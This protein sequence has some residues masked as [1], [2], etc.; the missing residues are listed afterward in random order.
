M[1]R[2]SPLSLLLLWLLLI[3]P[4]LRAESPASAPANDVM[5]AIRGDDW[6]RA[7]ALAGQI[8][9]PIAGKLV[10][11]YRLLAPGAPGAASAAS[12]DEIADFIAV[13]PDWPQ[14]DL[15]ARRRDEALVALADDRAA[16]AFCV[17]APPV[18]PMAWFRCAIAA[19]ASGDEAAALRAATLAWSAGI[20][21][22]VAT[23]TLLRR[24][25]LALTPAATWQRFTR[26]L[27]HSA[28]AAGGTFPELTPAQQAA[29]RAVLALRADQPDAADRLAALPEAT[30]AWPLVFLETAR[31]LRRAGRNT[32]ALALWQRS[33]VAAAGA[34]GDLG[35]AFWGERDKLARQALASGD[36]NTAYAVVDGVF[37]DDTAGAAL[38]SPAARADAIFLAGF[39]AL[40]SLHQPARAE[41]HFR[42][43]AALSPAVITQARAHY[44]LA[45][46]AAARGDG[47]GARAEYARAAHWPVTFY[48][49]RAAI[50]LGWPPARLSARILAL[51]DPAW[52]PAEG[53]DFARRDLT[54]AAALLVAWGAAT[55]ARPFLA[56]LAGL[57]PEPR[58]R[59]FVAHLGLSFGLPDAAVAIA[60]RAGRDGEMLPASGWPLAA[61]VPPQPVAAAT[62]LGL[63]RQESSFDAAAVSPSGALGLMQLLPGTA[64]QVARKLGL[65]LATADLTRDA[66]L[67]IRLGAAYL[68]ELLTRFDGALPLALAA[69]NAGPGNVANWLSVN[70]DPRAAAGGGSIDMLDW[71]ERIPFGETR[72]YV[73]RVSENIAVY[74]AKRR[75]P[76]VDPLA[77]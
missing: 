77:P 68:A 27:A 36:A 53:R 65:A 22:P 5:A 75:E 44:W 64:R 26:L 67:N 13:N 16:A 72:N 7:A 14:Q 71:I 55:R 21:D 63:I 41:S 20:D 18:L 39:I 10:T 54:R 25:P 51:R 42:A 32:E 47:A 33:G 40:E 4:P 74:R 29:A 15:L 69:Y 59:A 70:G 45:R 56:D 31:W 73:E 37:Q 50:A 28:E 62:V 3:A 46:A 2:R 30:R 17:R 9:D 52:S 8:A 43:L 24:W 76:L 57:A 34:A 60:R 1:R 19:A 12:A 58:Y 48:G 38:L 6:P 23:A 11:Y 61:S 35:A 66:G 49:Q